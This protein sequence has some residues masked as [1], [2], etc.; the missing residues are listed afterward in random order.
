[1]RARNWTRKRAHVVCVFV[2]ILF[3]VAAVIFL[4]L[5]DPKTNRAV[6]F[7]YIPYTVVPKL[8]SKDIQ[9]SL[10]VVVAVIM[11]T[12]PTFVVT[13][14]TIPTFCYL[15]DSMRAS[16]R[17]GGRLRWQGIRTVVLTAIIFSIA[18][19]PLALQSSG[20]LDPT[21]LVAFRLGV[22]TLVSLKRIARFL[23]AL[24]IMSNFYIYCFTVVSFR[25]F[26][27]S[28]ALAAWQCLQGILYQWCS[29]QCNERHEAEGVTNADMLMENLNAAATTGTGV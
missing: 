23:T 18:T 8:W 24:N 7:D 4:S 19:L 9:N 27:K 3:I 25:R 5:I 10:R 14:T 11:K 1:M 21:S 2:W 12:I 22:S 6:F 20:I 26:L 17:G 29:S 15:I 28:K 13:M 16:R